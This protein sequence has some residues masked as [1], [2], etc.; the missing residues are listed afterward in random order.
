MAQQKH[1]SKLNLHSVPKAIHPLEA[2][3]FPLIKKL[4]KPFVPKPDIGNKERKKFK[5]LKDKNII[6]PEFAV[7]NPKIFLGDNDYGDLKL[8]FCLIKPP[9]DK[10][11]DVRDWL[12]S[13]KDSYGSFSLYTIIGQF[14]FLVRFTCNEEERK[15]FENDLFQKLGVDKSNHKL[16]KY[17][18]LNVTE[19]LKYCYDAPKPDPASQLVDEKFLLELEEIQLGIEHTKAKETFVVNLALNSWIHGVNQVIDYPSFGGIIAFIF[20]H[21][22]FQDCQNILKNEPLSKCIKDLFRIEN[23]NVQGNLFDTLAICEFHPLDLENETEVYSP[24]YNIGKWSN[25]FSESFPLDDSMTFLAA[26]VITQS[27]D[28]YGNLSRVVSYVKEKFGESENTI[29]LGNVI[30]R[31]QDTHIALNAEKDWFYHHGLIYGTSGSGKTNTNVYLCQSLVEK[32]INVLYVTYS[33]TIK[34]IIKRLNLD[35]KKYSVYEDVKNVSNEEQLELLGDFVSRT[36]DHKGG[37]IGVISIRDYSEERTQKICSHIKKKIDEEKDSGQKPLNCLAIFDEILNSQNDDGK[38][39]GLKLVGECLQP[40]INTG[41][42]AGIGIF[43][44]LQTLKELKNIDLLGGF[45]NWLIHEVNEDDID[46]VM[47]KLSSCGLEEGDLLFQSLTKLKKGQAICSFHGC[48]DERR[49]LV[50]QIPKM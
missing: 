36:F 9:M 37:H 44:A 48:G 38:A 35:P 41:R 40:L 7:I 20:L 16:S 4:Q 1:N 29:I 21:A 14:D 43:L 2:K 31:G 10:Y 3:D 19:V 49:P 32:G 22:N 47:S 45:R 33:G 17:Q 24:F 12:N 13:L 5:E 11:Y 39:V 50:V 42:E 46:I 26:S 34:S 15:K 27:Q 28:V 30:D 18:V 25:A 8:R 23:L 6:G